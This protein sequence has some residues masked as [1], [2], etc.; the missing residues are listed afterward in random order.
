MRGDLDVS[1]QQHR[2]TGSARHDKAWACTVCA[3]AV[4]PTMGTRTGGGELLS[5]AEVRRRSSSQCM[6][7]AFIHAQRGQAEAYLFHSFLEV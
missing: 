4:G 2:L 7:T 1:A 3:D 6:R 5:R